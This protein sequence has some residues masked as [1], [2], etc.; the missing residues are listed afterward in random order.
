MA[1]PLAFS[2]EQYSNRE[3]PMS[4]EMNTATKAKPQKKK[5]K[6]KG[7]VSTVIFVVILIIGL[8][9]LLY[10]TV[11]DYINS[12]HSSKAIVQYDA[13]VEQMSDEEYEAFMSQAEQYNEDLR[14]LSFPFVE[15]ETQLHSEYLSALNVDGTSLMGYVSIPSIGVEIPI[16]HGTSDAVLASAAGHLEGSSLPIGGESR[17]AVI[18]A[19]R[20]LPSAKL[21]TD[22]DKVSVGDLF[23][24]TVLNQTLTYEVDQILIVEPTQ[25]E[26]LAVTEGK[27]Y[28]TLQT[29]TPYG[30]NTH[31]LLVRGHRV[32]TEEGGDV[33]VHADAYQV[34]VYIIIP[35]IA[36]P[37][38]IIVLILMIISTLGRSKYA[39][40]DEEI[41]LDTF[42]ADEQR[43]AKRAEKKLA[44]KKKKEQNEE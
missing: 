33:H 42:R 26:A 16:Y 9:V 32:E 39:R 13:Y 43:A 28:V 6:K 10:P 3:K 22:L 31:R 37:T 7:T 5:K 8:S 12:L 11:S 29:C 41:S 18:S 34:P 36:I 44:K 24:V 21:F 19:H 15:A 2:K 40:Y 20:G 35:A 23:Y 38:L 4:D 30:I 27:D 17:H 14:A 25:M 1:P